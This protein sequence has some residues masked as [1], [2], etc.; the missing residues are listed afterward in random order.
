MTYSSFLDAKTVR[1][2]SAM[3]LLLVACL[4]CSKEPDKEK[5]AAPAQETSESLLAKADSSFAAGQLDLAERDYRS[6]LRLAPKHP[7]AI[8]RL[9]LI[10][11]EQGQLPLAFPVLKAAAELQPDDAELQLKLAMVYLATRNYQEARQAALAVLEKTPGN[12]EAIILLA[13]TAHTPDAINEMRSLLDEIRSKGQEHAS[14]HVARGILDARQRETLA[15]AEREFEK[16]LELDPKSV[17]ALLAR[18]ALYWARNDIKAAGEAFGRAAEL[19]SPRS[20]AKLRYV[21]FLLATGSGAE[22]RLVLQDL[23][24]QFPW[25]LPPR[26]YLM[27]L[28]CAEKQDDNCVAQVQN[29]LA[30][31]PTNFDALFISG[32]LSFTKN[33]YPAAI[34]SYEQAIRLN[35]ESTPVLYNLA[36]AYLQ[37][38]QTAGGGDAQ[39]LV[40]LA[41]NVLTSATKLDPRHDGAA[42]LLAEIKIRKGNFPGAVAILA[43]ITR[44]RP[45][46]AQAH[47][48]LASAYLAQQNRSEALAV[49]RRM[50][51]LLPQNPQPLVLLGSLLAAGGQ[52]QDARAAFE[53]ANQVQPDLAPAIEG[54]VN[55]DLAE[56][57]YGSALER[58]NNQ[59][60]KNQSGAQWWAL[61]GRI[62][63]AE[64]DFGSAEQDLVKAIELAPELEVAHQALARVYLETDRP[65]LAIEKLGAFTERRQTAPSLMLLANLQELQ[66]QF[67]PARGTYEKVLAIV[68][69][70]VPALNNLAVLYSENFDQL[71]KAY[72]LAKKAREA[73]PNEPRIADTYGWILY[74]RGEYQEAAKLLS[75]SAA[76]LPDNTDVQFHN[77]I[78][79]YVLGQESAARASLQKAADAK[80]ESPIKKEAA[81]R[82]AFLNLDTSTGNSALR[83]EVET[84]LRHYPNDP[85]ATLRL[86]AIE[87]QS[88]DG[89]TAVRTLEKLVAAYPTLPPANRELAIAYGKYPTEAPSALDVA[90]RARKDY[91][92]DGEVARAYGILSYSGGNF[93]RA[94]EL[95]REVT[96]KG[97]PDPEA[98]LYLGRSYRGLAKLD[99]CKS[100]LEAALAMN[101]PS[102]LAEGGKKTLAECM[103]KQ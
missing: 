39:R 61:R 84:F 55:L 11:S 3:A 49:Y 59:L 54:L 6:V 96:S 82:L 12:E 68:P 80:I 14:Y 18:G 9:A 48:L 29:V 4:G 85:L 33:D 99:D 101:L 63:A 22:A 58:V 30:Q 93:E 60:Q 50:A 72:E 78:V 20:P 91:P 76:K 25:Y 83:N 34:R 57:N 13:E 2:L 52:S 37:T 17:N 35:G 88:G 19:S 62:K 98:M 38:A 69:N 97:Q 36:R 5:A 42:L 10:Y 8:R 95:L 77:G 45:S 24:K 21:D 16:A 70:Y 94:V 86:A 89:K 79:Q 81:A 100:T 102:E 71:E 26:V 56:R 47:L 74:K 40:D 15:N 31:A 7:L 73:V 92:Q 67:E 32:N 53:K 103:P 28:A 90:S 46:V 64:R 44:D 66:K 23:N 27:R 65:A 51:E 87:R 41:E 43:P 1:N 75:D